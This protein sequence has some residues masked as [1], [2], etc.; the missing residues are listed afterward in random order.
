MSIRLACLPFGAVFLLTA[1][2][3]IVLATRELRQLRRLRERGIRV[4]GIVVEFKSVRLGDSDVL[5]PL[6]R[7]RTVDGRVIE[8]VSKLSPGPLIG[9][10]HPG[11]PV[12]VVYDPENP[13]SSIVGGVPPN[14]WRNGALFIAVGTMFLLASLILLSVG[15]AAL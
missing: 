12:S 10:E 1:V 3:L 6:L 9:Q 13:T 11:Q 7:F 8:T 15:L 5:R 14:G 2:S 4:P